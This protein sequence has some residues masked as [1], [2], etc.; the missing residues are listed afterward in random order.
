MEDK[1]TVKFELRMRTASLT[2]RRQIFRY[3]AISETRPLT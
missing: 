2:R 1:L 3:I